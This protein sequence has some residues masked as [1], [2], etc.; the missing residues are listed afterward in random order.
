M[1]NDKTGALVRE[2]KQDIQF[3]FDKRLKKKDKA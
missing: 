2:K 1:I 3:Y